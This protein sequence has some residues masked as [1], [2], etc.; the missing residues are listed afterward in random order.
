M[1]L[2]RRVSELAPSPPIQMALS[3]A[4][5]AG[6]NRANSRKVA[7]MHLQFD[8]RGPLHAQ[9]TRAL[10]TAMISGRV[11][12]GARLPATRMLARELGVSRNTVLSAYE[13]LRAEGFIHGRTCSGSYATAPL[14]AD[15]RPPSPQLAVAEPQSTY[16][17]RA[18][19]FHDQSNVPG[20]TI[21]GMR[22]AFQY[23]VPLTNPA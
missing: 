2:L 19:S 9:L 6:S 1:A 20:R 3:R 23:G 13:Q 15:H 7:P 5:P 8:G 22:H 10:K 18:R 11:G 4:N 14:Q 16:A 12:A 17:R 21:P